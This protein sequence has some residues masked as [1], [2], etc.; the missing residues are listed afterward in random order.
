MLIKSQV[1]PLHLGR[2]CCTRGGGPAARTSLATGRQ[3]DGG[4]DRLSPCRS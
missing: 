1:H 4:A 2:G 3:A